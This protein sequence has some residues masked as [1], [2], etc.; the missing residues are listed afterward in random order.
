MSS[1]CWSF[2]YLQPE[3]S[4]WRHWVTYP[5]LEKGR[6][7][8]NKLRK[9]PAK[10]IPQ[11]EFKGVLHAHTYRSHD[12]RGVLSEILPA[13]KKAKLDFIFFSDHPHGQYDTFPH[14]YQGVYDGIIFQCGTETS[15]GLMVNPFDSVVIDWKKD[16]NEV[17]G[18]IV[19]NGGLVVYVHTE[20]PHNWSNPDYQAM[21][22]YNIHTD[23]KDE[24][25]LFPFIVNS[26][27]NG[28]KYRRWAYREIYDDQT[29]ILANWD[30]LN[31]NRRITGVAA[32][33]AHN[34]QSIRARYT[35]DGKVE[36]VGPD[37]KTMSMVSPGWKE[38]L[39]LGK[40]DVAGWAFKWEMDPYFYSFNYV[41]D[42]VFGDTLSAKSIENNI[43]K[44]HVYIAFESLAEA[45]GFQFFATNPAGALSGIMGD[46][47][48]LDS[49]QQLKVVSPLPVRF[50]LLR[51]GKV[52][53]ELKD[54]YA[55]NY[56]IQSKP[57][58]YRVTAS[59]WL[60]DQW[61][62]WI[63]TNPIYIQ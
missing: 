27:I 44:G 14:S 29:A 41:N 16:Q 61:V 7:A 12:S 10:F 17:I 5:R 38:K 34:N 60:G 62:P 3:L 52:I 31:E 45:D 43:V 37:A 21:E 39:L 40:P 53:N 47:M 32:V 59:L 2:L 33:D 22:I 42:H 25:S 50:Q 30:A 24:D 11:K 48:P 6:I 35:A 51:D 15:N 56:D 54:S 13:A 58:N 18:N 23:I 28:K 26:I 49:A 9:E 1:S 55:F 63:F 57:G 8:L 20:N 36:W 19:N 46:I 4:W